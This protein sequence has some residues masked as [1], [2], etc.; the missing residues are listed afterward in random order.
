MAW[1]DEISQNSIVALIESKT[2]EKVHV[3]TVSEAELQSTIAAAEQTLKSD[4]TDMRA[5]M[6]RT[7]GQYNNS[8]WIREDGTLANAKYLG[9]LDARELFPDFKPITFEAFLDELVA[10]T[11][12]KPYEE[13]V[14]TPLLGVK[15]KEEEERVTPRTE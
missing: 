15:G 1:S 12:K 14:F 7:G 4:P 6:G 11:L 2:G 3:D 9:Y 8:K 5:W 13:S 10:G